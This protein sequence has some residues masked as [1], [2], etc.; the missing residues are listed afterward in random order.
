MK[1]RT[2][3]EDGFTLIETMAAV[4]IVSIVLSV[5]VIATTLAFRRMSSPLD[6]LLFGVKLLRA[7][8][9]ARGGIEAVAVPYWEQNFDPILQEQSVVIP[10][11]EGRKKDHLGL[12]FSQDGE[13]IMETKSQGGTKRQVLMNNLDDAKIIVW[14]DETEVPRGIDII[15]R[16]HGRVYQTRSAFGA[17]PLRRA[18]P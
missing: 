1:N 13:L 15:Y 11:Y 6:F 18:L 16:Y 7:D 9:L 8:T 3:R 12:F 10:W 17:S 4:G 2:N 14:K 5:L